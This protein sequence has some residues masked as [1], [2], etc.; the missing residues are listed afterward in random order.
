VQ[1]FPAYTRE[2]MRRSTALARIIHGGRVGGGSEV[3]GATDR[4]GAWSAIGRVCELAG[5][6]SVGARCPG[7]QGGSLTARP[8]RRAQL[9]WWG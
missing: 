9:C 1:A 6:G 8:A 7:A 4:G 2:M 5:T 3:G